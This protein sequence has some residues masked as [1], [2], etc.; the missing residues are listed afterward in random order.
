MA[1]AATF[2]TFKT[3]KILKKAGFSETQVEAQIEV[4]NA[5]KE[6]IDNDV[7]TKHDIELV[8]KDIALTK[9]DIIIW[10]GSMIMVCIGASTTIIGFLIKM[11]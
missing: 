2:D 8:K 4:A 10:L 3:A 6:A 5:I 9:R 1:H 7:A 11:H